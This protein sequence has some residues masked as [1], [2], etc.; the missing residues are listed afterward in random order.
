MGLNQSTSQGQR[1][2]EAAAQGAVPAILVEKVSH[3]FGARKALDDVSLE[4]PQ[5][6]FTAL[7]GLNGAGKTTLF[8]LLTR[9]YDNVS[10]RIE[11]MGQDLRRKPTAALGRLGVV[12]QARTLDPDLTVLQ[13][14]TYHA[15]LHGHGRAEGKARAE[16]LLERI[17]LSDRI[18]DKVRGLSG[19]QARRVEIARSLLHD[20]RVLILDEPTVGLDIAARTEIVDLVRRLIEEDGLSVL[21]A[22]H[23]FDEV[24]PKDRVVL[25]HKGKIL[26][27]GTAEDIVGRSGEKTLA[28]AFRKITGTRQEDPA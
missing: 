1:T 22:T 13:N 11:I 3:A 28:G 25:M 5:G 2:R 27:R 23:L 19:G 24:R 6:E 15:A 18:G 8:S 26:G 20:P 21:W 4:V 17:S 16:K 12:F 14:F 9:L 7:L 10:G